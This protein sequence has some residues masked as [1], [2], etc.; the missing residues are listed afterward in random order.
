MPNSKSTL[1]GKSGESCHISFDATPNINWTLDEKVGYLANH[2][3][4]YFCQRIS[5]HSDPGEIRDAKDDVWKLLNQAE[6]DSSAIAHM[7]FP[8]GYSHD[9]SK[10]NGVDIRETGNM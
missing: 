9:F 3:D 8:Q 1:F 5:A 10:L 2:V 6:T 7:P 4:A